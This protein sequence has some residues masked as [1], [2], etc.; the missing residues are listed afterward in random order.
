MKYEH[1]LAKLSENILLRGEREYYAAVDSNNKTEFHSL[2]FY[3]CF[4]V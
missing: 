4:I 1:V 3:S 2:D